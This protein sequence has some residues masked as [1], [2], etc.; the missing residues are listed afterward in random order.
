MRASVSLRDRSAVR[1]YIYTK[2]SRR[3]EKLVRADADVKP[4][5]SISFY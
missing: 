2:T 5:N 1:P 3:R 4:L